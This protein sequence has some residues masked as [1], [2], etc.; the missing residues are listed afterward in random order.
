M[1]IAADMQ[2]HSVVEN[3]GFKHIVRVLEPRYNGPSHVHVSQSVSQLHLYS[4]PLVGNDWSKIVSYIV[5]HQ[6]CTIYPTECL[7]DL[8]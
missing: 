8:I 6:L 3:T 1:F 7:A 5:Y 4:T 2:P